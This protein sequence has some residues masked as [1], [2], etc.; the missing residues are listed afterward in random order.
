MKRIYYIGNGF[1]VLHCEAF[2]KLQ[3][4][5][6]VG[7]LV[8]F[9]VSDVKVNEIITTDLPVKMEEMTLEEAQ[10]S[11]AMGLFIN[12]YDSEKVKVYS[13]GDV[14]KEI[15]GGPHVERT[16]TM[17]HFR[18]VKEEASSAGVRRIKAVLE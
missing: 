10:K 16:G 13:V 7:N 17:G 1:V 11:G 5:K 18:I 9:L 12:K 14:S 6:S 15:C 8:F 4:N 3:G 2:R